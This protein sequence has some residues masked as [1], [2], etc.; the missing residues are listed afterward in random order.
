MF[1]VLGIRKKRR[2]MKTRIRDTV[3]EK[4]KARKGKRDFISVAH[5][6]MEDIFSCFH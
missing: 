1:A 2:G 6:S 3:R 4:E 5:F